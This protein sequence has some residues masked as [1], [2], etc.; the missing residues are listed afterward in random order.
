MTGE[1]EGMLIICTKCAAYSADRVVKLK[2]RCPGTSKARQAGLT[3]LGKGRRPQCPNTWVDKVWDAHPVLHRPVRPGQPGTPQPSLVLQ[4]AAGPQQGPKGNMLPRGAVHPILAGSGAP[5]APSWP[6]GT[7]GVEICMHFHVSGGTSSCP[8][9]V[10]SIA[11]A[12]LQRGCCHGRLGSPHQTTGGYYPE[13]P[14][15]AL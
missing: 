5:I 7:S 11:M 13:H 10:A 2:S 9:W 6:A 3:R 14:L 8:C 1:R 4:R 12:W 15:N